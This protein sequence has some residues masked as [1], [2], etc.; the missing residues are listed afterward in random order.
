M[1]KGDTVILNITSMGDDG[2]G[3]AVGD[4]V[5]FIKGALE[6]EKVVAEIDHTD[7]KGRAFG[8][9]K[10]VLQA[11]PG[12]RKPLCPLFGRCGGCELQ[13]MDYASQLVF[14]K[15]SFERTMRK[16][17]GISVDASVTPSPSEQGYRN[18]IQ[19]P[20]RE[21]G[22]RARCGFFEKNSHKLVPVEECPL[23]GEW[24]KLFISAVDEYLE[25]SGVVPY[26]EDGRGVLRNVIGR[27]V[28]DQ[29]LFTAVVRRGR[30]PK[31]EILVSALEKRF[32][33]FGLFVSLNEVDN[34]VILGEKTGHLYGI[35]RIEG[36]TCGVK[37]LLRPESFFQVNDGIRSS[38]YSKAV[39]LAG[40]GA[41]MIVDAFSGTGVMTLMLAK[42]GAQTFGV[43]LS[44]SAIQDARENA[45]LN[46]TENVSFIQGDV[47]TELPRLLSSLRGRRVSVVCDPARKGI[48][49]AALESI[50]VLRPERFVYVSCKA[51][52]QA[53]DLAFFNRVSSGEYRVE[54][55]GI[56]DQFPQTLSCES[57]VCMK[58]E[59]KE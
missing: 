3:I 44:A 17:G 30:L 27:Y 45:R 59:N 5:Y 4:E 21:Y 49:E 18:K 38:L 25:K 53:R 51:S 46:K 13:H 52:T 2:C 36:E 41:E 15:N 37:I 31:P 50:A 6:G 19:F 42:G 1:K 23:H 8:R 55:A 32:D 12:R 28:S 39:E 43:E 14:K 29:L 48:G 56:F 54:Y 26:S 40:N 34:N 16:I 57:I 10:K 22:G 35:G 20:I 33:R 7:K 47:V 24:G 58:R 9:L 11:A